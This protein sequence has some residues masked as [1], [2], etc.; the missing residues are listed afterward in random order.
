[1]AG[2]AAAF[3]DLDGTLTD[4][5][6]GITRCIQYA[7]DRLDEEI[8][9]ADD[10]EWCIGPPLISSMATLVGE[11]RAHLAVEY[12]RERFA[13]VGW[14]ENRPYEGIADLLDDLHS[15]QI[16]LYVATS[17][18]HVFANRIL[19][20]FHLGGYF[21]RVYGSELDGTNVDK[22]DLL[23]SALS[24]TKVPERTVM[25][26][27]RSHDIAGALANGMETIGVT[28]GY[29]SYNEL[30]SAGAHQIVDAP[31]GIL[32]TFST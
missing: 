1:M 11:K 6:P 14:A 18:P 3:F 5:K 30:K 17:K 12:Y 9:D 16:R 2:K 21:I 24:E 10:L 7:L 19:E 28:Y 22:A 31:A 13:D 4:P 23:S 26:G 32:S 29:G 8:P 20:H 15:L 25:I 27:D